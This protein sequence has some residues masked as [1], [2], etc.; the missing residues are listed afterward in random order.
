MQHL[1][2]CW[3]SEHFL[4]I[5]CSACLR[6]VHCF[7]SSRLWVFRRKPAVKTFILLL[8]TTA[9]GVGCLK[10]CSQKVASC[11]SASSKSGTR[12]CGRI[13][14][15]WECCCFQHIKRIALS[16]R[17]C[18]RPCSRFTFVHSTLYCDCFWCHWFTCT[19]ATDCRSTFCH[20]VASLFWEAVLCSALRRS[21]RFVLWAYAEMIQWILAGIYIE[22]FIVKQN[23]NSL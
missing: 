23:C 20:V 18:R 13:F 5:P 11:S 21:F 9:R 19:G 7:L 4:V 15:N 14:D 10:L 2:K 12:C 16:W 6:C 3:M 17:D 1:Q 22:Q 8:N